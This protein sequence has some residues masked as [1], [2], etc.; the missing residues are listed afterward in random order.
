VALDLA[1]LIDPAHTLVANECQRGVIG[2]R[3]LLPELARVAGP[4]I[5]KR[6]SPPRPAAHGGARGAGADDEQEHQ[7]QREPGAPRHRWFSLHS[8]PPCAL[9][10]TVRSNTSS[11]AT[12]GE[13]HEFASGGG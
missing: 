1:R 5:P 11:G 12:S 9:E 4:I 2:D 8:T 7:S 6:G 3:S 13:R 10:S